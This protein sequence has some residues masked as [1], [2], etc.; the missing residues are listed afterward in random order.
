M[1][2]QNLPYE[3]LTRKPI[4]TITL[5]KLIVSIFCSIW[6]KLAT[7]IL[8]ILFLS[9]LQRFSDAVLFVTFFGFLNCIYVDSFDNIFFVGAAVVI[10]AR[11]YVK[12]VQFIAR[13]CLFNRCV[14]YGL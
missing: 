9:L 6:M 13:S 8:V 3:A 12:S 1:K 7:K 5:A 10:F 11:D 2:L 14:H 4:K